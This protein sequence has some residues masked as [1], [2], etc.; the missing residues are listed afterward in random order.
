MRLI[1]RKAVCRKLDIGLTH[2]QELRADPA[3]GFPRPLR[4]GA[5]SIRWVEDEIDEYI[6]NCKRLAA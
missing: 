2:L 3:S 4:V 5:R 1:D 6:S